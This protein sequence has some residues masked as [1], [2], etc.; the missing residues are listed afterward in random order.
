MSSVDKFLK[1]VMMNNFLQD[2][3][4]D[5][6]KFYNNDFDI[7]TQKNTSIVI[8]KRK[9]HIVY[10]DINYALKKLCRIKAK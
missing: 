5:V 2:K 10:N 4:G 7:I 8:D 6:T 9:Q 1:C 3:T